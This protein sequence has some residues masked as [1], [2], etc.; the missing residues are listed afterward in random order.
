MQLH[1]IRANIDENLQKQ[2]FHH[3]EPNE[4]NQINRRLKRKKQSRKSEE[5]TQN[6]KD[7]EFLNKQK[8][9]L[10]NE[11]LIE[12][13]SK[14]FDV[15]SDETFEGLD[16]FVELIEDITTTTTTEAPKRKILPRLKI[17]DLK[18]RLAN[19]RAKQNKK[20]QK[21][22]D[23]ITTTELASTVFTDDPKVELNLKQ[24][25]LTHNIESPRIENKKNVDDL[26]GETRQKRLNTG[27]KKIDHEIL[28]VEENINKKLDEILQILS[29]NSNKPSISKED[30]KI[31]LK[32][33][34]TKKDNSE[35]DKDEENNLQLPL[36]DEIQ[37]EEPSDEYFDSQEDVLE[38]IPTANLIKKIL[39]PTT[40]KNEAKEDKKSKLLMKLNIPLNAAYKNKLINKNL[41]MKNLLLKYE[42]TTP[43]ISDFSEENSNSE[44]N[45]SEE[46]YD[47]YD[48]LDLLQNSEPT[49]FEPKIISTRST[50]TFKNIKPTYFQPTEKTLLEKE[51][52]MLS[53]HRNK[54]N[55]LRNKIHARRQQNLFEKN[56][57]MT[58]EIDDE[59]YKN[60]HLTLRNN[61]TKNTDTKTLDESK[62]NLEQLLNEHLNSQERQDTELSIPKILRFTENKINLPLILLQNEDGTVEIVLDK[63]ELCSQLNGGKCPHG[64]K[65]LCKRKTEEDLTKYPLNIFNILKDTKKPTEDITKQDF[66]KKI[67]NEKLFEL[68]KSLNIDVNNSQELHSYIDDMP[69]KQKSELKQ[70]LLNSLSNTQTDSNQINKDFSAKHQPTSENNRLYFKIK[71]DDKI[72]SKKNHFL[73]DI[74]KNL[75]HNQIQK[76]LV[77]TNVCP[78]CKKNQCFCKNLDK[79]FFP[80][81]YSSEYSDSES[82]RVLGKRQNNKIVTEDSD[83]SSDISPHGTVKRRYKIVHNI[84]DWVHDVMVH[85]N[86]IV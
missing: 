32:N 18:M 35:E 61:G 37:T 29:H 20:Q 45:N 72:T 54:L 84:L 79:V 9:E 67:I 48:L 31:K 21:T 41:D 46:L 1:R 36:M 26:L 16:D 44:S 39:N 81:D 13:S 50:N 43:Q 5:T 75:L 85:N 47:D 68:F 69:E 8:S 22:E 19:L 15:A 23:I 56:I 51:N 27:P 3:S 7:T 62:L 24:E 28:E 77:N 10:L 40:D 42:T 74:L 70:Y 14:I 59:K 2:N 65:S 60:F 12:N 34:L 57:N 80:P 78:S 71:P 4:Q 86:T 25:K 64:E 55:E 30:M 38:P 33:I 63:A 76:E 73:S 58:P 49:A 52:K 83:N 66:Y 53:V 11:A 17:S 6:N 82:S